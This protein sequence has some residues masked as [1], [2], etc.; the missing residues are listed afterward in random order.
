MCWQQLPDIDLQEAPDIAALDVPPPKIP[1]D[2]DRKPGDAEEASAH[3]VL[4]QKA[5]DKTTAE[6][7]KQGA[8]VPPGLLP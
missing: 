1:V 3:P 2:N 7:H 5:G 6:Q 4:T 8:R